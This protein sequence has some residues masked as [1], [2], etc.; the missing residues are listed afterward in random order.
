MNKTILITGTR[1]GIGRELSR[2]YLRKGFIILGCSRGKVDIK[3]KNYLHYSLD[4]AEE[5]AVV[6]M[7]RDI[8]KRFDKI[9]VLINNAGIASM[10]HIALTPYESV[11]SIFDTNFLGTFLFIREVSKVMV[12]QKYG[13]IVNFTTVAVPLRLEGEAVYAASKSAVE[14]LT[15]IAA[16][17]LGKFGITVNAIGPAPI[18][19]DLTKNVPQKKIDALLER[20]TIRRFSEVRDIANVIDFFI[21]EKSDFITGQVIYLGGING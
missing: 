20:Q 7:V 14:T 21:G 6:E 15:Q 8:V 9:D 18:Q 10:N 4:V 13:R 3:H 19:T 2:Y 12:R 5:K 17:E 11:K 1:K 16:K